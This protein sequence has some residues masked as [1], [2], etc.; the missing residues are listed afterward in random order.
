MKRTFIF[1]LVALFLILSSCQKEDVELNTSTETIPLMGEISEENEVWSKFAK[2]FAAAMYDN[3]SLRDLVKK[4][5]LKKFDKDYDVLYFTIK[6]KVLSDGLTVHNL[7]SA[8]IEE[9]ELTKMEYTLPLLTLYVPELPDFS[10]EKWDADTESPKIAVLPQGENNVILFDENGTEEA[11]EPHL[12]PAFPVIVL[13]TNERVTLAENS[14][15]ARS[16]E[17]SFTSSN[18]SFSFIDDSFDSKSHKTVPNGREVWHIHKDMR[19][20]AAFWL[21][22]NNYID[23]HRDFIYYNLDSRSRTRGPLI[24]N[25][26]ETIVSLGFESDIDGM[27]A[28]TKIADQGGDP[29]A[30][31][32]K[33]HPSEPT[34][35]EGNFEF[36]VTVLINAKSGLGPTIRKVFPIEAE[37]LF[38]VAY[39]KQSFY[40]VVDKITTKTCYPDIEIRPWDL[41]NYSIEWLFNVEERDGTQTETY[42]KEFTTS[43]AANFGFN[44]KGESE[45]IGLN[46]GGTASDSEKETHTIVTTQGS[47]DLGQAALSFK[48]PVYIR[49]RKLS[50][51]FAYYY[52][53]EITTGWLTM[54]VEPK[55]IY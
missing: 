28:Y 53:K 12:I 51:G 19:A 17:S 7:L 26:E 31:R 3:S 8:Y 39:R 4:E 15:N 54:S 49:K 18:L 30:D 9:K 5:A 2:A 33:F 29:F 24:R 27:T 46:F 50:N 6:D 22:N 32:I 42:Q 10:A 34:W 41:E 20:D 11:I 48:D 45:K 47:D 13:K 37:E 21:Y 1:P 35:M 36:V 55:K 25:Y 52:T 44:S 38:D 14:I 43:F 23:W 16:S 40:Y